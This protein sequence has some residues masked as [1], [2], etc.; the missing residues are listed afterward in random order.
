MIPTIIILA[1]ITPP[2]AAVSVGDT[3]PFE[4]HVCNEWVNK[5]AAGFRL[6]GH[7]VLVREKLEPGDEGAH[8]FLCANPGEFLKLVDLP[9]IGTRNII[10]FG[11]EPQV[12][13]GAWRLNNA[14]G[15][16]RAVMSLLVP[17]IRGLKNFAPVVMAEP[18]ALVEKNSEHPEDSALKQALADALNISVQ[19]LTPANLTTLLTGI[20]GARKRMDADQKAQDRVADDGPSLLDTRLDDPEETTV[21]VEAFKAIP[22]GLPPA[23][24]E[25]AADAPPAPPE[26]PRSVTRRTPR[27][28]A[29][30]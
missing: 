14:G 1:T 9:D 11:T 5:E 6:P 20:T 12:N 15:E 10:V 28:P 16:Q 19:E 4:L 8:G 27:L 13:T 26:A 7:Q 29:K 24:P 2:H 17:I 23:P 22:S 25:S 3:T 18:V 21:D 30:V